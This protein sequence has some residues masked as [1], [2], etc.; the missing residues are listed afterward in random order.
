MVKGFAGTS[1]E[2]VIKNAGKHKVSEE[3]IKYLVERMEAKGMEIAKEVVKIVKKDNRTI[4]TEQD[5]IDAV[6]NLRK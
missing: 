6:Y 2:Y 1:V 4:A 5:V 3:A